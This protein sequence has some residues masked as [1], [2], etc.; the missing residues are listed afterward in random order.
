MPDVVHHSR[1]FAV[2]EDELSAVERFCKA[3]KLDEIARICAELR[4]LRAEYLKQTNR[5]AKQRAMIEALEHNPNIRYSKE[6]DSMIA[7]NRESKD[8][9]SVP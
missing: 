9:P 8:A 6:L 5:V 3:N 4:V 7:M 1:P 2:T